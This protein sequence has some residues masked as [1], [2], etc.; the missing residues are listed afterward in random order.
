M[1]SFKVML[2]GPAREAIDAS[3]IKVEVPVSEIAVTVAGL[4]EAV[5]DQYPALKE[6]LVV[7]RFSVDQ[8]LIRDESGMVIQKDT[9]LALIPPISGG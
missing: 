6:L 2:F 5:A 7:S 4:R 8:E 9:E 3:D 1:A